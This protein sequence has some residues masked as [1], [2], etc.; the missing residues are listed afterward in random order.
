MNAPLTDEENLGITKAVISETLQSLN[1]VNSSDL[2]YS[3]MML[4]QEID[5]EIDMLLVDKDQLTLTSLHVRNIFELHLILLHVFTNK[6]AINS[7]MGQMHKDV[8]D[9]IDG[10]NALLLSK[11]NKKR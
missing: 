5:R 11:K 9:I 1:D 3:L 4:L 7:W 10:F 6:K 2:H 8:K